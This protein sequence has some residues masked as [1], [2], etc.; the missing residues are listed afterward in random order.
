MKATT[1]PR[2]RSLRI[3]GLAACL[4]ILV[5]GMKW[6]TFER[7]GSPMPDWDQWDAEAGELLIPWFERENFV[8]HLFNPH[9]E[10]R[11]VL[12]KLQNLG[13]VLANGQW[14]SR[15]EAVTNAFLHA[16]LA[17]A[18]WVMGRRW[19]APRWHAALFLLAVVL[20]GLPLAWQNVLGGFHSQ[21]Y[22]LLGLSCITIAVL[23]FA[24]PWRAAWWTGVAAA[25][26]ALGSM[27]SG[28]VAA[29]VVG[30]VL[31]WRI[32]RRQSTWREAW[33]TLLICAA[34]IAVGL[35]TRVHVPWHEDI[36]AK[37]LHDFVFSIVHS[38][39]WP[40]RHQHWAALVMW[41][42]WLLLAWR[43][44]KP[45]SPASSDAIA[46]QTLLALGGW[47]LIQIVGTAYARGVGAEYPA[48]RYMDT[49]TFATMANGIGLAWMLS[50]R[51][52]APRVWRVAVPVV[53]LAWLITLGFGLRHLLRDVLLIELPGAK[54]YYVKAENNMRRYLTTDNRKIL[55]DPA[56]PY[57]NADGLRERLA[58]P[59]LRALMPI[60]IR[61][62]LTLQPAQTSA[63][64]RENDTRPFAWNKAPR[65][66]LSP[67][68][69]PLETAVTWGSFAPTGAEGSAIGEWRS[70]PVTASLPGWLKFETAGHLGNPNGGVALELRS[71]A[72][73]RLLATVRPSKVPG[74]TWRAA[75][76]RSP[77]EPF[78]VVA[79][80]EH[81]ARW[82]AFSPP[83]EMG[84]WSYLAWQATKHG[85]FIAGL[86]AFLA[87]ALAIAH[88]W[89]ARCDPASETAALAPEGG[90][91][92]A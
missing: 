66:G 65:A 92:R 32:W 12:T 68:T 46:A 2:W 25:V 88:A 43:V 87:A 13:L 37:T 72:T 21:Q 1:S 90:L 78:I 3:A 22:W 50:G 45:L 48:S 71:A 47:V 77:R 23:P 17:V 26:L 49:L 16:A 27:G 4:F 70:G 34:I 60:P 38:L 18:F 39:E 85:L 63:V 56:I 59:H 53:A 80:D 84:R 11:V 41:L 19:T 51:A 73:D 52:P 64:F 86:A 40:L 61:A 30:V 6:A 28:F 67:A 9:N 54:E 10:H 75:Y 35:A 7:F 29:G 82:L 62:P 79:R 31:A 15:L 69:A 44:L 33:P 58:N 74:D 55:E 83:V 20:F 36:K 8:T 24:R 57:P 91:K 76:V 81:V 14:D 42:P 5:L 89:C